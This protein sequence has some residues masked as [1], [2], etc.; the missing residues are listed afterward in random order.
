MERMGMLLSFS[1][2]SHQAE[3]DAGWEQ[4]SGDVEKYANN[5]ECSGNAV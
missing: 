4:R 2:S 5:K 3:A 1:S